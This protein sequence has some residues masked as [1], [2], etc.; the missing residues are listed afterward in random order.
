V[1]QA[2]YLRSGGSGSLRGQ[3]E[4]LIDRAGEAAGG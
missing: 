4:E 2:M 3:V 1:V